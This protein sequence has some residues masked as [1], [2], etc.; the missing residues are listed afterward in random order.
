M[1][2][3]AAFVSNAAA[4]GAAAAVVGVVIGIVVMDEDD[5]TMTMPEVE[6]TL[7]SDVSV[8]PSTDA[9]EVVSP[10]IQ[11]ETLTESA[12]DDSPEAASQEV[13]ETDTVPADASAEITTTS[14]PSPEF[15]Q[16]RVAP[17]GATVVAGRGPAMAEI[18]LLLDGTE[19]AVAQTG[20]GGSFATILTLAPSDAPRV[21]TLTAEL[22]DG[23]M[24][25]G[26]QSVIVSPFAGTSATPDVA[27]Q[28]PP[29]LA[30][31]VPDDSPDAPMEMA[32]APVDAAPEMPAATAADT[33]ATAAEAV[34]EGVAAAD[35]IMEPAI[36]L[37]EVATLEQPDAGTPEVASPDTSSQD[38]AQATPESD[39]PETVMSEGTA[40]TPQ[41]ASA[42]PD[43]AT[44]APDTAV[45]AA[46]TGAQVALAPADIMPETTAPEP[47]MSDTS[48]PETQEPDT[49]GSDIAATEMADSATVTTD[50]APADT[51][52]QDATPTITVDQDTALASVAPEVSVEAPDAAQ[53]GTATASEASG[54]GTEGPIAPQT[55]E[56][57]GL[58]ENPMPDPGATAPSV[59]AVPLPEV[60]PEAPSV[61]ADATAEVASDAPT[62]ASDSLPDSTPPNIDI[63]SATPEPRAPTVII[64]GPEGVRVA[65]SSTP[66]SALTV[67][68][69]DAISYDLAGEVVLSGRGPAAARVEV[70]LNNEPVQMGAI[71][72]SG[73]WTLD[74]PDVNPGTYTLRVRQLSDAGDVEASV[75]TPFL[76]EDPEQIAASTAS[77]ESGVSIIT[78]QPGFTL[79]GIAEA[80][81]GDGI[82]Y[83]QIF[84]ENRDQIRD[85]NWIFPGQIFRLPE[86]VDLPSVE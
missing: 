20:G 50:V 39:A 13:A 40:D 27:A 67:L 37:A 2:L 75:E 43:A 73:N 54:A 61:V 58:G 48:G 8:V 9:P 34:A 51:A 31:I 24:L 42:Q 46:T 38:V 77:A 16:V 1:K 4:I 22:E 72:A 14:E 15:D 78:V 30:E 59:S 17:D 86:S 81:F 21:L 79:W 82:A 84:E 12:P 68:Q 71:A 63:A 64:A 45:A 57:A 33:T 65:Q 80:T 29:V 3:T 85:P 49:S 74:L 47:T 25:N 36:E 60:S 44:D 62:P 66:P 10:E 53:A 6:A 19:V 76:R 41:V 69:I 26:R 18:T 23:Q 70:T 83:V 35:G 11:A 28:E 56:M 5:A 55:T 32:E 52:T 7:A